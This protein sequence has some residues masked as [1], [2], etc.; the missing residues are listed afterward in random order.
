MLSALQ[1]VDK[2]FGEARKKAE[3]FSAATKNISMGAKEAGKA[4]EKAAPKMGKFASSIAR[5][6]KYRMIRAVIRG[7]VDAIKEGWNNF[8][9]FSKRT[10][11]KYL[12]FANKLKAVQSAAGTMKNQLGAAFAT[13]FASIQP[14][15]IQ[16]INLV[17]R[18]ANALTMLFARLGGQSGWY[19]A[20]DGANA[21]ADAIGGAGAAA[22][23]ALKYLAP[24][25]ELNV[26]PS[27]DNGGGGGGGSSGSGGDYEWVPFEDFD[28]G[29]GIQA[30]V[31]W[32]TDAFKGAA[33]WLENVN[34]SEL[35]GKIAT[36]ISDEFDKLNVDELASAIAEFVG[37]A[38]GAVSAFT[39]GGLNT[40][41]DWVDQ[42]IYDAFHNSDGSKKTGQEIIDWILRGLSSGTFVGGFWIPQS[43]IDSFVEGFKKAFGEISPEEYSGIMSVFVGGLFGGGA[44]NTDAIKEWFGG[45]IKKIE[46]LFGGGAIP[47]V[48]LGISLPI[49]LN[50]PEGFAEKLKGIKDAWNKIKTKKAELT[51]KLKGTKESAFKT[52]ASKWEVIKTKTSELTA[53]LKNNVQT[54]VIDKLKEGWNAI[55]NKTATFTAN[56]KNNTIVQKFI[57]AW[58]GLKDKALSLKVGISETVRSAWNTVVRKWNGSWLAKQLGTIPELASGGMLNAGQ[59]FVARENGAELVGQYGSKTGVMNNEQIVTAVANGIAK[60]LSDMRFSV[61]SSQSYSYNNSGMDEESMYRAMLRALNAADRQPIEV[62]L[63]GEPIYRGVVNRNRKE[64]F[65]TG[66]NPMLAR[67]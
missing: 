33:E 49:S 30:I 48:G 14:I 56:L 35:P 24:F 17:V 34:W 52:L 53:N 54:N 39:L 58:N 43:V 51:A 46:E 55:Q 50:I 12:D 13:L 25:D 7:I 41:V 38:V 4:A 27:N 19:K 11:E 47:G 23:K 1:K 5:I 66:S 29:D 8:S 2:G 26:L 57:D 22:K 42:K 10:G 60:V 59:I 36:W 45:I 40:L 62:D 9:E 67:A 18:L 15:L 44:I 3:Q 65:R 16:L 28:L 64:T 31:Q 32:F 6:A 37:A 61:S 63:D 20:A 21:A